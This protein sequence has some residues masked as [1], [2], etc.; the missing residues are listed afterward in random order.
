MAESPHERHQAD[1]LAFSAVVPAAGVGARMRAPARKPLLLLDGIPILFH[2]L[3]RLSLAEGC[4]EIVV[5][6][7][8]DDVDYYHDRWWGEMQSRFGVG[9]LVAGGPSRQASVLAALEATDPHVELVLIHD[10]VRPLV[11]VE[12]VE[13]VAARVAE[14]GAAIAAAPA[15]A[16]VKEVD[17][18]GIICDTPPRELLW[19]A[20]TPQGFRRPL[21]LQAHRK[22][23]EEGFVGTDDALLAERIGH[24]V[25]VVED[26]PDNIK[27]TTPQDLAIAEAI[28]RWQREEGVKGADL[29]GGE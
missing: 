23:L 26:R 6:V 21:A 9:A 8:P 13:Q 5:A 22:A 17:G 14:C 12:L 29:S 3:W 16:T 7:N 18:E 24:P 11:R 15:V 27:I 19:M 1:P 10:A 25:A 20:H 28:L 2:T 4:G